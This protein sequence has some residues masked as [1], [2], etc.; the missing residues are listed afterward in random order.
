M[1]D[2]LK[3]INLFIPGAAKSGTTSLH[4]LLD[5]HPEINMSTNKEP[6]FFT[7]PK[8]KFKNS[9][10]YLANFD[11]SKKYS[12]RGES[13]TGYFYFKNF[14]ENI[15]AAAHPNSKFI[16]IFRNPIDR[17][18]SHYNYLKSL[19]SEDLDLKAAVLKDHQKEPTPDDLLPELI[20]KNYYQYSLYGKWLTEFYKHF[21]AENIKVILF[22]DLKENPLKTVNSCLRFLKLEEVTEIPEIKSNK[23]VKILFPK[24]YRSIRI[25]AFNKSKFRDGVKFLLPVKFRRKYKKKITEVFLNLMKTNKSLPKATETERKWL[26]NLYKNDVKQLKK[27]TGISYNQWKDFNED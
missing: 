11:F 16:L 5:L 2:K 23:T 17:T 1:D 10:E 3:Q 6:H 14:K 7:F 13:S 4:S 19:G 18:F 27:I 22:E 15:K 20:V 12:Y 26:Y 8:E 9:E 25:F 21:K 24:L